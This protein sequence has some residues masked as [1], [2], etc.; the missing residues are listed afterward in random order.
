MLLC[1][2]IFRCVCMLARASVYMHTVKC[3]QMYVFAWSVSTDVCMECVSVFAWSIYRC[4]RE[5]CVYRC[6]CVKCVSADVC[7]KRVYRCTCLRKVC[8]YRYLREV[9]VDVCVCVKCVYR[10]LCEVCLQMFAWSVC[11]CMCLR[12]A[13]LQMFAWSVPKCSMHCPCVRVKQIQKYRYT[14]TDTKATFTN[15]EVFILFYA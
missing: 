13:C 14:A 6:I 7:V 10:C 11:R 5:V 4:L 9:S 8:V 2:C 12:E 3:L 1:V 15:Q